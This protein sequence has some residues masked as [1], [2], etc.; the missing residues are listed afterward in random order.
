MYD[1][2]IIIYLAPGS[3]CQ[4]CVLEK[5]YAEFNIDP[6]EKNQLKLKT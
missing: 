5:G 2:K 3:G 1:V 4:K 6:R